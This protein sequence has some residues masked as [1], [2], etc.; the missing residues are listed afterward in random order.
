MY[1]A[2]HQEAR[3]AVLH[4]I[5]VI[6]ADPEADDEGVV[7]ALTATGVSPLD[8]ELLMVFVPS[9]FGLVLAQRLGVSTLPTTYQ[10]QDVGGAWVSRPLAEQHYFAAALGV[11]YEVMERG[12][13]E[14]IERAAFEACAYRSAEFACVNEALNAGV[15]VTGSQLHPLALLRLQAEDMAAVLGPAV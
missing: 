15:D 6:A 3:R 7:R 4:A 10:V 11:A 2:D 1:P 12:W 9:A 5:H 13:G 8:A 14:P